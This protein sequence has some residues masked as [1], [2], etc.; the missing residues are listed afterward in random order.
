MANIS[1]E[2]GVVKKDGGRQVKLLLVS[3]RTKKHININIT[4]ECGEYKVYKDGRIKITSDYKYFK[5]EDILSDYKK[6]LNEVL[7][8]S[9]G[10]RKTAEELYILMTRK[11][12]SDIQ[13]MNFFEFAD[14]FISNSEIKGK[15][16]YTTMLNSLQRYNK[17]IRILPFS[18]LDYS[19]LNGYLL[20][21]KCHKRAQ[22]LY[23][24]AIRHIYKQ[25]CL[26]YNDDYNTPIV[27][28][29]FDRFKVPKQ[30]ISGQRS[31]SVDVL[32][33]FFA[34]NPRTKREI[35]AKDCCML[36]F[37]LMGTNSVDLYNA[38]IY[39]DGKIIYNRSKTK[40]R[41]NDNAR[42]EIEV[43]DII[44]PLL[45][46]YKSIDCKHVF[47]FSNMYCTYAQLNKSIN[48]GLSSI[49]KCIGV[50]KIQFYQFRHSWA[51]IARNDLKASAY[52][53]DDALNHKNRTNSLLDVYVKKDYTI[54]NELNKRVIEYVFNLND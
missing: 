30:K 7:L 18:M 19:F 28:T 29:L 17:G 20:Y 8:S 51:S 9:I 34:F 45:L 2:Y 54:I 37:C 3:G 47:T 6:K 53:V 35:I 32:R 38:D 23:L 33:K 12:L 52:D 24:G 49:S 39:K 40:D 42:I 14:N 1:I 43:H 21:L 46:K 25:A 5:I 31:L 50:D 10:V 16:N 13:S 41:R 44:K 15:K 22:S 27:P 48:I 4:L 36:S 26:M 11:S